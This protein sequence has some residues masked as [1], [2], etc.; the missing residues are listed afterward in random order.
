[1]E[2]FK[3]SLERVSIKFKNRFAIGFIIFSF[4]LLLVKKMREERYIDYCCV[5]IVK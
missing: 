3:E 1:M 5:K 4:V 2:Q